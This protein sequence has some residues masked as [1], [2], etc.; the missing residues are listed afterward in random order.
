MSVFALEVV[1][2]PAFG[3]SLHL[4]ECFSDFSDFYHCAETIPTTHR[5]GQPA[6]AVG[7]QSE[8][9]VPGRVMHEESL[10]FHCHLQLGPLQISPFCIHFHSNALLATKTA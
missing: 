6:W 8:P 3:Y 9:H 2:P 7:C 10:R 1:M 5:E 4:T